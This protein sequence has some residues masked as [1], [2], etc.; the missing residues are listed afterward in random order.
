MSGKAASS[1]KYPRWF[2]IGALACQFSQL[3][4]PAW[5]DDE[6]TRAADVLALPAERALQGFPVHLQGVVTVAEKYWKGRFFVNDESGGVFVD[7]VSTNQPRVGDLVDVRGIS[8][9]G[10]FAP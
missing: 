6:L 3:A 1:L 5:A 2:L 4:T 7:N 10:A 8:H 9:P